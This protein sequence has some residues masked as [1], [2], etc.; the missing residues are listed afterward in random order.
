MRKGFT[1]IELLV[2]L[3]IL[4]V[5]VLGGVLMITARGNLRNSPVFAWMFPRESAA[6]SLQQMADN[7]EQ[8]SRS[9][10]STVHAAQPLE[11]AM[12]IS[13]VLRGDLSGR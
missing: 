4:A 9:P 11:H 8:S 1:L 7:N 13:L 6:L 12:T 10:S 3:M 5:L 2:V